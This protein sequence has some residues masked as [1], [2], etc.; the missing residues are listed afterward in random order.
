MADKRRKKRTDPSKDF[1]NLICSLYGDA[2]DDREE[3][4]KP[5]GE[6]WEP[7]MKALHTSLA[8]FRKTLIDDYGIELSTAKIRK[9]LITGGLWST[10][11][12]REIAALYEKHHDIKRVAKELG[13][14]EAL[15]T[16]YLPY[17]RVVYDL[18]EKSGGAKRCDRWRRRKRTPSQK[19]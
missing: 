8:A 11:R 17:E 2:Y 15:V 4:S 1:I 6:D 10:E 12:S 19:L 14:S 18:E 9:I 16:M 13:V 3:D 7:G 5:G